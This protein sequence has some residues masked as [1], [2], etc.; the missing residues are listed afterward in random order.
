VSSDV[1]DKLLY[2]QRLGFQYD[3]PIE[4]MHLHADGIPMWTAD[5]PLA[6]GHDRQIDDTPSSNV[7]L[8]STQPIDNTP[9]DGIT[10]S[11]I[12]ADV[13][14]ECIVHQLSRNQLRL[15][16][17]HHIH[18]RRVAKMHEAADG[19]SKV[20][21]ATELDTCPVCAYAKLHKAARG[22]TSSRRATQCYQGIL[23]D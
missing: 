22:Q 8:N 16:W 18:S 11:L 23:V 4:D 2:I 1:A 6:C 3:T 7:D 17:H 21:I 5:C 12:P 10:P 9:M 14:D 20:P 13:E 19:V 15:L